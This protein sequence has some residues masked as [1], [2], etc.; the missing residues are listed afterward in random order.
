M[1]YGSYGLFEGEV[2]DT[3]E[4][5]CTDT[6]KWGSFG[7]IGLK[8]GMNFFWGPGIDPPPATQQVQDKHHTTSYGEIFKY[9]M[10]QT[11]AEL[12]GIH[13]EE[14]WYTDFVLKNKTGIHARKKVCN[15]KGQAC[16]KHNTMGYIVNFLTPD[17]KKKKEEVSL[18][19]SKIPKAKPGHQGG[20]IS[21]EEFERQAK[22]EL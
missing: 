3:V 18:R 21:K 2:I 15:K 11:C 19:K 6:E 20:K 5:L 22:E 8:N 1:R 10:K 17:Q 4:K 12:V 14:D 7:A 16:D 9:R 13:P